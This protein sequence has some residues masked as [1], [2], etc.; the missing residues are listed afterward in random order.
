MIR[1]YV[2]GPMTGLPEFNFP[3][4]HDAATRLRARGWEVEN[5]AENPEPACRSWLGYMRMA[6][7]Q[8]AKV[9]ALVMLPGWEKSKGARVEF[10]LAVGLGL[11]VWTLEE[12]LSL[13]PAAPGEQPA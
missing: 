11:S 7:A 12:A 5:P 3:A 9:D 8:V 2:A 4:F 13:T 10:A 6:V 1:A